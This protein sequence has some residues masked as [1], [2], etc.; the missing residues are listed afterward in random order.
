LKKIKKLVTEYLTVEYDM[1][2]WPISFSGGG[3]VW[4]KIN[5]HDTMYV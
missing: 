4:N 3:N 5:N 1:I 2:I